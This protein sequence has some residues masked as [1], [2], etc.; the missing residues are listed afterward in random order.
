MIV[1]FIFIKTRPKMEVRT[2]R[3]LMKVKEITELTPLFGDYDLIAKIETRNF[4]ILSRIV[5]NKIRTLPGV[6]DTATVPGTKI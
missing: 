4:N 2:Y 6:E 1:G 5:L 3:D